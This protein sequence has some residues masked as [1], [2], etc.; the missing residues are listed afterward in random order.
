MEFSTFVIAIVVLAVLVIYMGIKSVPQS[1]EWTVERFGKFTGLLRPGLNIIVPF[2]DRIGAKISVREQVIDVPSQDVI[3]NDNAMV[4]VDGVVFFQIID[5]VKAAYEVAGL[6]NAIVNLTMTNIRTVMGE[7][8]LDGLLSNREKIN[9]TLLGVIDDATNPWGVKVTRIEIKDITPAPDLVQSMARQMK[10]EREKRA[11]ILEAEG[12]REAAI[13]EAQG[14]R[15]AAIL[16]AEGDKEAEFRA[17]EARERSAQA[18]AAATQMVSEAI[19]KG[20]IK[21]VNYFVAQKYVDALK[22]VASADNS[23]LI[24]MPLD[25][26]GVIGALGGVAELAKEAFNKK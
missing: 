21:A 1:E 13:L 25:S 4:R 2:V 5:S 17:A 22:H 9:A 7:M 12:V 11:T 14:R 6:E 26:S 15:Q 18:E 3:T 10:A 8:V 19:A 16:K 23:K 24:F 20:D